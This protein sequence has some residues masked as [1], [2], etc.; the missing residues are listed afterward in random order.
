MTLNKSVGNMY[1]WCNFTWNPIK[2]ECPHMC[3]YCYVNK[4]NKRYGLRQLPLRLDNNCLNDKLGAEKTIFVGS[5]TDMWADAVPSEWIIKVL[6][7]CNSFAY[8]TY[9]FQTKNPERFFEFINYN[10]FP[11]NA[12]L[13]TTI[14]TNRNT[15]VSK[16]PQPMIRYLHMCLLRARKMVSIEPVIGFDLHKFVSMIE[17]INPEFV[18]IGA[19]SQRCGLPEPSPE[20]L[21]ELIVELRKFTEVRIK[22]NLNRLLL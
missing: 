21:K 8:N 15:S 22:D 13:G 20:K 11:K 2:G 3:A 16:A 9:L 1:P 18:S 4:I 6:K 5:S 12:I 19:D 10:Y 7:L 17:K 14:E